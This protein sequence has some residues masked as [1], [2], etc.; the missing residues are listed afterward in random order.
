MITNDP[1][2]ISREQ[3]EIRRYLYEIVE[4]V[5][6]KSRLLVL[7]QLFLYTK[8]RVLHNCIKAMCKMCCNVSTEQAMNVS[9]TMLVNPNEDTHLTI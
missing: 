6:L 5:G 1:S 9:I 3:F 4:T 7:I 2:M 8:K